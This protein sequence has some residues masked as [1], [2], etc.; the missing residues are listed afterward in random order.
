MNK[1]TQSKLSSKLLNDTTN[2]LN[3]GT[4]FLVPLIESGYECHAEWDI[5]GQDF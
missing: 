1:N 3:H 4:E 5:Y 2:R